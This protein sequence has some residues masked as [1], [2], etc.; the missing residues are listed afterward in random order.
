M[1]GPCPIHKGDNPH[2]FVVDLQLNLW[3]CF[4]GCQTGGDVIEL[5]RHLDQR[6]YRE[7]AIYLQ[8]FVGHHSAHI[9]KPTF[10]P[11]T[12]C[13]PLDAQSSWLR[14]KGIAVKT[15]ISFEVGE[16]RYAGFLSG[17]VGVRLHNLQGQPLGYAGRRLNPHTVK[18]YGKWKFPKAFP[19]AIL[20]N[21]VWI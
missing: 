16:Y 10:R 6:S 18:Q 20:F 17:C 2:A 4:T 1:I 11:F 15:A 14:K 21:C 12:R 8:K 9:A 5:V 19:L 13:L 3:H 7:V